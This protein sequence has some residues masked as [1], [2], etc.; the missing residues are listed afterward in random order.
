LDLNRFSKKEYPVKLKIVKTSAIEIIH[1][2]YLIDEED[3]FLLKDF[4]R[5]AK[6]IFKKYVDFDSPLLPY[7]ESHMKYLSLD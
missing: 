6:E 4:V 1:I 2:L 3:N 5:I 7:S